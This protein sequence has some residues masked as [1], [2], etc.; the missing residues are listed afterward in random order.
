MLRE[1]DPFALF[2]LEPGFS[3]DTSALSAVYREL[4]R[5][6]HPDRHALAGEAERLAAARRAAGVNDAYRILRDPIARARFLLE[7]LEGGTA[8]DSVTVRDPAF[9]M[10]QMTLRE[11]LDALRDH[12]DAAALARMAEDLDARERAAADS[13]ERAWQVGDATAARRALDTM[14]FLSRLRED[15]DSLVD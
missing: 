6:L 11:A 7:R 9:L 10:E 13:F 5:A 2:G 12:P 14:R 8:D 1:D 4:Q 15:V 3:I